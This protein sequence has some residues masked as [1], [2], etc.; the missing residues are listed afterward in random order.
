MSTDV[1]PILAYV[2]DEQAKFNIAL[3]A[4]FK[5][6]AES[7]TV[8][9]PIVS[10]KKAKRS[11]SAGGASRAK[12]GY[13]MFV[14]EFIA[15]LKRDGVAS[16][17]EKGKGMRGGGKVEEEERVCGEKLERKRARMRLG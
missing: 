13:S 5:S 15:G 16:L 4:A 10:A 2:I 3:A 1:G 8:P 6:W 11:K 7:G 12:S 9:Q 17:R 14:A